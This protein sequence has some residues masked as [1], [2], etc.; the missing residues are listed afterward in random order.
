[1]SVS[2]TAQTTTGVLRHP[3]FRGIRPDVD[4]RDCTEIVDGPDEIL[5]E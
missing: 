2:F 4:A 1:V 3:V 5:P